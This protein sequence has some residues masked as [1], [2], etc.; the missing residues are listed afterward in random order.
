MSA[1]LVIKRPLVILEKAV[2]LEKW[3]WKAEFKGLR[4]K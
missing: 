3:G 4:R 1:D 2:S